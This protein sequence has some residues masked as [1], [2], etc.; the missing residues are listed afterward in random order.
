ME[1]NRH[2]LQLDRLLNPRSIAIIG[3]SEK[4]MYGKGIF[5]NLREHRFGG[6]VF[7]VNPKRDEIFGQK[8][9]K[10]LRDIGEQVDLAIIIISRKLV[11]AALQECVDQ[12]VNGVL[13]ISSGFAEAD[14]CGKEL[15]Q[16]VREFASNY[17]LPV[18]GPNCAGY[19]N[20]KDRVVATLLREEG[21]TPIPGKASFISQSGALM[22]SLLGVARDKGLGL[23]YAISSGNEAVLEASDFLNYLLDDPSNRVFTAFVEGFKDAGKFTRTAE[24]A[25][26][27]SIP[28]CVLKVGRSKLGEK[29][30]ASHTGSI[31]G[32]D[33]AYEAVFKKYGI[34]RVHDTDELFETARVFS[35]VTKWPASEAIA[36]ITSSGGT[37]SLSADLCAD[38]DLLLPDPSPECKK[39]L[40]ELEELLTFD[41]LSNPIDVRGQGIRALDKILPIV[42]GDPEFGVVVVAICFSAV[43]AV[44]NG[45]ATGVRDA[46]LN[47]DSDKPVF[48]LWV[49]RRQRLGDTGEIDEG[50]EILERAGIPVFHSPE[51]CF[52]T[53]RKAIDF[54]RARSRHF[55]RKHRPC[56]S[57][58]SGQIQDVKKIIGNTSHALTEHAS[59]K[60]LS[61]YEIPVTNEELA[62]SL[63]D[64]VE[65]AEKI[66]YPVAMKV[67]S[68]QI[69]H[70]TEANVCALNIGDSAELKETYYRLMANAAQSCPDAKIQGML[71]QQMV[72][73]GVEVVLGMKKDRQF[74]PL[75]MFGLGGIFVEVLK[76]VSFAVPPIDE[77][78]AIE[79]I[80][81]IK[82]N[83][84]LQ[85][86]RTRSRYDIDALV[87]LIVKFSSLCMDSSEFI[88]EIDV[89]PLVVRE[90]G[91]TVLDA[92]VVLS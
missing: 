13:I 9:F 81:S 48:V 10:T 1:E 38:H 63:E 51:L 12:K 76:D 16:R 58:A 18:W 31:T 77:V 26:E 50:Y 67:M 3:A 82:G 34:A 19:A 33:A 55:A 53:I 6:K 5:E 35:S 11:M 71:V 61:L 68:P 4:S 84:I 85:G 37:G 80:R 57:R 29:A 40:L 24:R 22:M 56:S 74:G 92:L 88:N 78:D 43:G 21:R 89:N 70:K 90:Q 79:M 45:V 30:A 49:G 2:L 83:A 73:S 72:P 27:R 64:A 65:I 28:L 25:L 91:V 44:A 20:F 87:N 42:A 60:I 39:R 32:Q 54:S 15:E 75:I 8:C 59:K 14:E 52:K 62:G 7:P 66:Q 46:I 47:L 41:T 23:N 36:V 69:L 86:V 17:N